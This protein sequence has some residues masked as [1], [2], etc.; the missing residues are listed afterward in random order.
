MWFALSDPCRKADSQV[1]IEKNGDIAD[2]DDIFADEVKWINDNSDV[3]G[4]G[5]VARDVEDLRYSGLYLY[6]MYLAMTYMYIH[7]LLFP[8]VSLYLK[9]RY[10]LHVPLSYSFENNTWYCY[11]RS[12]VISIPRQF[13]DRCAQVL[14]RPHNYI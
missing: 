7:S 1:F 5:V 3:I 9:H 12:S 4:E 14:Y 13:S 6:L 2:S 8:C 11:K 10:L